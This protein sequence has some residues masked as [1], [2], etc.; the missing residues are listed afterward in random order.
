MLANRK[1]RVILFFSFMFIISIAFFDKTGCNFKGGIY[2]AE[3]YEENDMKLKRAGF[4]DLTGT[5]IYIDDSDPDY[6]WSK[7]AADNDW[8]SGEGTLD[9]PY[10]I[11]N[12][13]IDGEDIDS[14]ITIFNSDV[15]FI[16]RNCTLFNAREEWDRGG[17]RLERVEHG[18][19][20]NNTLRDCYNGIHINDNCIN[21][22]IVENVARNNILNAFDIAGLSYSNISHNLFRNNDYWGIDM[23]ISHDNLISWNTFKDNSLAVTW[24]GGGILLDWSDD[25]EITHN[26]IIHN[27][28]AGIYIDEYSNNNDICDNYL[29]QNTHGIELGGQNGNNN[30]YRN[31]IKGNGYGVFLSTSHPDDNTF[32]LNHF[33]DNNIH[34]VDDSIYD[35]YL[36]NGIIG[37]YWDDYLGSDANDDGIG[38]TPHSIVVTWY[39]RV[40]NYPIWREFPQLVINTPQPFDIYGTNAP[41]FNI[42]A[43]DPNLVAVW[44]SM[45][46][47][48]T[49]TPV[50]ANTT[51]DQSLWSNMPDGLINITFYANDTIGNVNTSSVL[52]TKDTFAPSV[53]INTPLPNAVYYTSG[54]SFN[55][56]ISELTLEYSWYT[57]SNNLTKFFF[58]TNGSI[59]ESL[60]DSLSDGQFRITFHANDSL[61][62]LSS[63]YVDIYKDTRLPQIYVR[64][65]TYE[66][67]FGSVAPAFVVDVY[68][69]NIKRM[70]YEI[71]NNL[72]QYNFTTNTTINQAA[73]DA[74]ANGDVYIYFY[75]EDISERDDWTSLKI[76]KNASIEP[77]DDEPQ[78]GQPDI[79]PGYNF[80]F[81]VGFVLITSYIIKKKA[82]RHP[83]K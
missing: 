73:W 34:L 45:D 58:T 52:V 51:I 12:V 29:T 36:D 48:A 37:N 42:R 66:Q 77:P 33:I 50:I 53:S 1:F 61:S 75:V 20:I 76:I 60:W 19:I 65:P 79:I 14:C 69:A 39:T 83:I 71:G 21:I 57:I 55:V 54:P 78:D 38:D 16:I 32:Y 7:T 68:E 81:I 80:T 40:D 28:R 70:W 59:S 2:N 31:I 64:S 43:T 30:I 18:L 72:I 56:E 6:N 23:A 10:I 17:I 9:D 13:T 41:S 27:N 4:W 63:A 74:V 67:V 5:R 26:D 62:R 15:H 11:E 49:N 25:N 3:Y 8:C 46:G 44:Y 22:T 35:V 24:D 82:K 47:G